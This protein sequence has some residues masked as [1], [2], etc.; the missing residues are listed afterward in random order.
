MSRGLGQVQRAALAAIEAADGGMVS[1]FE[2]GAAVYS[3]EPEQ[4]TEV[5]LVSVRRALRSLQGRGRVEGRRGFR[6]NRQQ[7][8][9]AG[10]WEQWDERVARAFGR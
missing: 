9:V 3:V 5:Q 8:R 1:T 4:L 6:H 7:W 2:I 10:G